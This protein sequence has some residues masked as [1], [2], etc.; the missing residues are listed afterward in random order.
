MPKKIVLILGASQLHAINNP[1]TNSE[2]M[3]EKLNKLDSDSSR[4]YIQASIPNA[5]YHEL[6]WIR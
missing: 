3:I 2:L 5:N 1:E 6:Y 4:I